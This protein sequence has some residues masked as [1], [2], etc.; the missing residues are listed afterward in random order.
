D[1]A[2]DA[3]RDRPAAEQDRLVAP[4]TGGGDDRAGLR[5]VS[6]EGGGGRGASVPRGHGT[7]GP[8][9]PGPRGGRLLRDPLAA[10]ARR[11]A[12]PR[13]EQRVGLGHG[14]ESLFVAA[15]AEAI[16]DDA[17]ARRTAAE[18]EGAGQHAQEDDRGGDEA[19]EEERPRGPAGPEHEGQSRSAAL[20]LQPV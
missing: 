11:A 14:N 2:V 12:R 13:R 15:A 6:V 5:A 20:D 7:G 18:G 8:G 1:E 17:P 3:D 4:L 9:A 19:R 10:R 16:G